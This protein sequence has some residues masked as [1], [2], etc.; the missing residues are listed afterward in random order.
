MVG[1]YWLPAENCGEMFDK[2]LIVFATYHLRALFSKIMIRILLKVF[3]I[4]M[5]IKNACP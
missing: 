1:F 5:P 4:S 3:D 2:Y